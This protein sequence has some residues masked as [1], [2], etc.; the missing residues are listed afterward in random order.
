MS[1]SCN[2]GHERLR[3]AKVFCA[4]TALTLGGFIY[5]AFREKTLL[6]F[7]WIGYLGLEDYLQAIRNFLLGHGIV[8]EPWVLYSLPNALWM[9]SGVI[10]LDLIWDSKE[11]R[12]FGLAWILGFSG[13]AISAELL[14]SLSLLPGTFDIF[15]LFVMVVVLVAYISA[16][17]IER[18]FGK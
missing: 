10:L 6:M 9:L 16:T 18:R 12:K 11:Y 3:A 5:L 17:G 1:S 14:Q 8:V 4:V 15:D 2:L 13:L 7:S